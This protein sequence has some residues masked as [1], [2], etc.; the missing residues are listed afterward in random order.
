M[1]HSMGLLSVSDTRLTQV[2][3]RRT[4]SSYNFSNRN[5]SHIFKRTRTTRTLKSFRHHTR[6]HRHFRNLIYH[7]NYTRIHHLSTRNFNG[8][9]RT[10]STNR[11]IPNRSVQRRRDVTSTVHGIM[12]PT[13]QVNRHVR[14]TSPNVTRHRTN[15]RT[16]NNRIF[17]HLRIIQ[18]NMNLKRH[19]NSR[20]SHTGHRNVNGHQNVRQRV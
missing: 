8:V 4:L 3:T 9:L 1:N 15:R 6:H 2:I 14:H 13:R 7:V 20:L 11:F 17:A 5:Q 10:L 12:T 19:L 18:I 16:N